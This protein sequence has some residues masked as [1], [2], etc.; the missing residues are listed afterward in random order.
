MSGVLVV[1]LQTSEVDQETVVRMHPDLGRIRPTDSVLTGSCFH[2]SGNTISI[3]ATLSPASSLAHPQQS[4]RNQTVFES[5][6]QRPYRFKY[7]SRFAT[8]SHDREVRFRQRFCGSTCNTKAH[9]FSVAQNYKD[10]SELPATP[11]S[12]G[13]EGKQAR[14][15]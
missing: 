6:V 7:V 11:A 4:D 8:R 9:S 12:F 10:L 2:S 15:H 14:W 3:V 1:A 5:I 13:K